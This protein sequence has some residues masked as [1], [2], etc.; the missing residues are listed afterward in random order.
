MSLELVNTLATLGTFLVIAATAIVA[1]VQLRHARGSVQITALNELREQME[2]E[3][4]QA[5]RHFVATELTEKLKDP[6][7]RYQLA[8][9]TARTGETQISSTKVSA[10]GNFYE[11]MG[12]LVKSGLIDRK[13]AL[14]MWSY[15]IISDWKD[16]TPVMA[17]S[18]RH[19]GSALWENFEYMTVMSEDWIA[20]HPDG[21]YERGMRRA[22]Y[23]DKWLEA[24]RQ[25]AAS[26]ATA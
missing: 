13:M 11:G 16:I 8:H 2:S 4:F 18:R 25:Y 9:P 20:A 19:A 6:V 10:V 21:T 3:Q 12:V 1:I 23:D 22:T 15:R 17:I 14:E 7:F 26:L 5:A 24:D